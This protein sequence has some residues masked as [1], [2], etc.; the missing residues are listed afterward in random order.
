MTPV[1]PVIYDDYEVLEEFVS[2]ISKAGAFQAKVDRK[3]RGTL[4]LLKYS[5]Y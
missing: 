2:Q 1:F 4:L 3:E 5:N